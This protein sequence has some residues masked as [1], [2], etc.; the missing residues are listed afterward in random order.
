MGD[1]RVCCEQPNDVLTDDRLFPSSLSL[2]LPPPNPDPSSIGEESWVTA[3]QTTQEVVCF[4]QPNLATDQKRTEVIE[5]VHRLIRSRLGCEV[6]PYGSVPLKTYLPDGD[7]DLT[8]LGSPN[9]EDALARDVLAVLQEEEQNENAEYEVKDAQFIDA[10][11]KL[12]KCLVQ[13]IVIDISFNQLGGLCTLCFLEQIDR[14]VGKNHLFKRSII[15][16]KAWCYYESRILGA[17]HGLISTYALETLVLYIFH[18]FHS[19]LN[20]PLAVLYRFLDYFSKFDWENYCVSLNGPVCK[21]SLPDIFAEMPKNWEDDFM[22]SEEFLR[23]CTDMF[24][25]PSRG[26]ENKLRAFP[27]KHLNIIDPLK[28]NNNLGRSVH[29]GNFYRIRSAFKYGARKLGGI[30]LLPSERIADEIKKFFANTLERHGSKLMLDLQNLALT[31]GVKGSGTL[32]SSFHPKT[33]SEVGMCLKSSSADCDN[34]ISGVEN[35]QA[36]V[37]RNELDR[38]SMEVASSKVVSEMGFSTDGIAVS[39]YHLA[40]DVNSIIENDTSDCSPQGR[41]FSSSPSGQYYYAPYFFFSGSSTENGNLH[42]EKPVN[43]DDDKMSFDPWV[44]YR[45]NQLVAG[46]RISSCSNN[47]ECVSSSGSAISSPDANI[48]EKFSLD[49]REGDFAG[50]SGGLETFNPLSDLSGDYDSHIRSLL[51]GQC[52]HGYALSAPVLPN[53]LTMPS[54]FRDKKPWETVR[55]SMPLKRNSCSR[56]NTN[57]VLGPTFHPVDNPTPSIAAF[58]SEEKHKPRGTGTY[59]PNMNGGSCKERSSQGRGRNQAPGNHRRLQRHTRNSGLAPILPEA[60]SSEVGSHELPHAQSQVLGRG[61]SGLSRQS[62][63]PVLGNSYANGFSILSPEVEFG[64]FG[65]LEEESNQ[66]ASGTYHARVAT[67][68]LASPEL[69][70]SKPVVSNIQRRVAEQSYHLKNEDDFPPLS[71]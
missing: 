31:S 69:H 56:I 61:K 18:V 5:Y 66:L 57:G 20:G 40:G 19:S 17:H 23:N 33:F 34:T 38:Y 25:V 11:V 36:N 58:G 68:S 55:R 8:A 45:E 10:E 9:V 60:N 39:G 6:F 26:I 28:E 27:Q 30:L 7:I 52:C 37:F 71:L 46:N 54:Q 16:I 12:V 63:H 65:H 53:P 22:L 2:P 13:N 67:P 42:P 51:Y 44:E 29:R 59:L 49:F 70:G 62:H 15:L 35:K 64:S 48:L 4:I 3:E 41:N 24:S 14:L 21:S 43:F 1:L 47:N 32:S 50:T